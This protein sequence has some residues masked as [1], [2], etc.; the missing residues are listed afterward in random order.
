MD[1][2]HSDR[3]GGFTL[4]EL[5]ILFAVS[6]SGSVVVTLFTTRLLSGIRKNNAAALFL[7]GGLLI[8]A[9]VFIVFLAALFY[10]LFYFGAETGDFIHLIRLGV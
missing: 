2:V 4:I 5:L 8:H 7:G 10:V 1:D 3:P 9:L 6:I